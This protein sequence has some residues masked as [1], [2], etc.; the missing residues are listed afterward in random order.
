[1]KPVLLCLCLAALHGLQAQI[2]VQNPSFEGPLVQGQLPEFWRNICALT[3]TP[4]IQ[5]GFLEVTAP[6][7]DGGSYVQLLCRSDGTNEGIRQQLGPRV[8]TGAADPDQVYYF[9]IWLASYNPGTYRF[10]QPA[11]LQLWLARSSAQPCEQ[12]LLV[13]ESPPVGHADWQPYLA[14][15]RVP[16]GSS[17]DILQFESAHPAQGF[18]NGNVMLDAMSD[19]IRAAILPRLG[20]D[21]AFCAGGAATLAL[22]DTVSYTWQ[23][24]SSAPTFRAAETGTYW[25]DISLHGIT[26]RDSIRITVWP[27]PEPDLGPDTVLCLGDALTLEAGSG[28]TFRWQDQSAAYSLTVS[29]PGQYW[30][31][32]G[33]GLCS[34]RDTVEIGFQDCETLL[35]MPNVFTPN[36]DGVCDLLEPMQVKNVYSPEWAIFD[37]WGRVMHEA[38]SLQT[39]WDGRFGGGPAPAG[40]Y[41]YQIR[42]RTLLGEPG[43][44]RGS[45][46][47][48][49]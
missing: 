24:G 44:K 29:A 37:R 27:V 18:V 2:P 34:S 22:P 10:R 30:V 11:Q 19:S 38:N 35:D 39:G 17:Y 49:R 26:Y 36:G 31:E 13:W 16:P 28:S 41:L 45:F 25:A 15:F 5:P 3:S 20:P 42:Y 1:M 23:N 48:L 33:N 14:V 43:L 8:L 32:T 6:P 9:R 21:T 12:K 40:V 4:D 47:L 7:R 46:T